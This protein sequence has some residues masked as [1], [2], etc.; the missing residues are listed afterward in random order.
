MISFYSQRT[1]LESP[2]VITGRTDG[3]YRLVVQR[4]DPV[5]GDVLLELVALACAR[6]D[7]RR[8]LVL[9]VR[10]KGRGH[11]VG[12]FRLKLGPLRLSLRGT[13]FGRHAILAVRP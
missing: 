11:G 6:A 4:R 13:A 12:D 10:A 7:A 8:G 2:R 9:R 3:E 1:W 5:I